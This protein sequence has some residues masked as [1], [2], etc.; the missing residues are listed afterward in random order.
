MTGHKLT[1]EVIER[2]LGTWVVKLPDPKDKSV[3]VYGEGMSLPAA[4]RALAT[5]IESRAVMHWQQALKAAEA[6]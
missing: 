5:D 4:L 1:L 3:N 2:D 6:C